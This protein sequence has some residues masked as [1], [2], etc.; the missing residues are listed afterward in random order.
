MEIPPKLKSLYRHWDFHVQISPRLDGDTV[1]KDQSLFTDI[2]WFI[3]E[4]MSIWEQKV[5]GAPPPY[6]EDPILAQYRFCNIFREFD[7]QTIEIHTLLNPLRNN[8]PRWL[9]NIFYCRMVARPETIR[10]TGLLS[11]EAAESKKLYE[12][13]MHTPRPR[14]GTPYIFP[15]STIQKSKTPTRELFISRYLPRVMKAVATEILTWEKRSVYDG[16]QSIIPIFDY[17]LYFLWTEVLID[18]AYQFPQYIDLFERFPIGPGALP[19]LKRMNP[20][21]DPSLLVQ[22]LSRVNIDIGLTYS[23]RPIQLSAENW[24]GIG[25]EYRKYTNLKAGQGRKRIFKNNGTLA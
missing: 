5:S 17:N 24:E 16:L 13:L 11:F 4:R 2:S 8:F 7:R 19:T 22:D 6:T 1:V 18:V 15:I 10:L 20:D 25:C 9:L 3:H 12:K 21:R 14:F 23:G